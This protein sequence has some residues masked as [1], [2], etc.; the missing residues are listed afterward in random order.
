MNY[1]DDFVLC[2]NYLFNA[3]LC[4]IIMSIFAKDLN[5]YFFCYEKTFIP[6]G[7]NSDSYG[8]M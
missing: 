5:Y 1:D 4:P 7:N 2:T 3:L 8:C 6:F